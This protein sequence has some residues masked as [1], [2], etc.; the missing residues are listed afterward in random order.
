MIVPTDSTQLY[1][2][3]DPIDMRKNIDGLAYLLVD[4]FEQDPQSDA[5]FIFT[6][7]SR[8][9]IKLLAWD[10]NGFVLY[11]KRLEKGR[12]QYSKYLQGDKIVITKSV[13]KA[14]LMGLDFHIVS[15]HPEQK[16]TDFI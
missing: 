3:L 9:K 8:N 11:Y 13:L 10:K 7:K 15:Q 6:N 16:Y 2:Y 12:F 14:L 1:V 4:Q 5:F